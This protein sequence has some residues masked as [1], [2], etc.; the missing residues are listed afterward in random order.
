M[1]RRAFVALFAAER[2]ETSAK[3]FGARRFGVEIP[4]WFGRDLSRI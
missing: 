1:D 4:E 2:S 3:N